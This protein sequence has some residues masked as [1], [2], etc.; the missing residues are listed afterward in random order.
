MSRTSVSDEPGSMVGLWVELWG[1]DHWMR[2][3]SVR[4][5]VASALPSDGEIS[6]P[7]GVMPYRC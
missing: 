3:G 6:H 2:P 1:T 7:N 5:K 4:R